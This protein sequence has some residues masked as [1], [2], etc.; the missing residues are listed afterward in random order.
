MP[1]VRPIVVVNEL[2][3]VTLED[4]RSRAT[5]S[6]TLS[7]GTIA[8]YK[9]NVIRALVERGVITINARTGV[10]RIAAVDVQLKPP[11]TPRKPRVAATELF[12]RQHLAS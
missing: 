11:V 2:Q 1:R 4:L 5:T 7:A 6:G 8:D 9:A 3:M 10:H 12:G